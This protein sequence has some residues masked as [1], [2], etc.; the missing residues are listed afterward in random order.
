MITK[1]ELF[2]I[3]SPTRLLR[4]LKKEN[5]FYLV[6]K[7]Y[8]EKYLKKHLNIYSNTCIKIIW[9]EQNVLRQGLV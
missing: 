3:T 6:L 9:K 5:I 4:E 8:S 1:E 2:E 7:Q